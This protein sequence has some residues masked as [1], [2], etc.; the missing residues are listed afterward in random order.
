LRRRLAATGPDRLDAAAVIELPGEA[1]IALA[2]SGAAIERGLRLG[3]G[4]SMAASRRGLRRAPG[5]IIA[6]SSGL[7]FVVVLLVG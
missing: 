4:E 5:R 6:C 1:Q 2:D 7:L 3:P